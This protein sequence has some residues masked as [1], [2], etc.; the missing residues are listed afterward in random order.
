M[1]GSN[2]R[3]DF[4]EY[5]GERFMSMFDDY[6]QQLEKK[7]KSRKSYGSINEDEKGTL[8]KTMSDTNGSDSRTNVEE[9]QQDERGGASDSSRDE[10]DDIFTQRHERSAKEGKKKKARQS[11][12]KSGI[13][14][15]KAPGAGDGQGNLATSLEHEEKLRLERKRFMASKA[16]VFLRGG[17]IG[18][19]NSRNSARGKK[20]HEAESEMEEF[21]K[22][23]REIQSFGASG[24]GKKSRAM[25][26]SQRLIELGAK[27]QK[28]V[29]IPASIGLGMAKKAA[30][31]EQRSLREAIDSGM[32]SR[33]SLAA[34][35]RRDKKAN[36]DKGL[37]EDKGS[38]RNG[39]LHVSPHQ[40][41][42]KRKR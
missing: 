17:E 11:S 5:H 39:V 31:R 20:A 13:A 2:T 15:K 3:N 32:V 8:N 10:L 36:I 33:K 24:L 29:R 21:L 19:Q 16:D 38:F 40:T 12:M 37:Y 1:G 18:V 7:K 14:K 9:R 42:S 30:Q 34:K 35:K 28:G 41:N 6:D 27:K 4:L 23:R 22:I 26:E 25:F